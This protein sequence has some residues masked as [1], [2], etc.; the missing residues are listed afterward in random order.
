MD[1]TQ[2]F[3]VIGVGYFVV[4]IAVLIGVATGMIRLEGGVDHD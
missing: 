1:L 2:V 3:A 4:T